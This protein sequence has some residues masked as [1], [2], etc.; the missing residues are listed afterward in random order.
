VDISDAAAVISWLFET[1]DY[2][3]L[4]P[5][6]D[7]CDANDDGR[8]DLA[9]SVYILRYLFKLPNTKPPI[10]FDLPGTDDQS[11]ARTPNDRL[12]CVAGSVCGPAQI[13]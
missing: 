3:F 4:P 2:R 9:D 7:A 1:G 13:P 10:P 12:D 11:G 6:M 8:V 5:C